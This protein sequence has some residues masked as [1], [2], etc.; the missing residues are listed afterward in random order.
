MNSL[1][2]GFG[3]GDGGGLSDEVAEAGAV[4]VAR[5]RR[6]G[7]RE[8]SGAKTPP[9]EPSTGPLPVV[10]SDSGSFRWLPTEE[11]QSETTWLLEQ[12]DM[13]WLVQNRG[14]GRDRGRHYCEAR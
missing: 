13:P 2:L 6:A 11:S 3:G 7:A 5:K 1:G 14:Q 9:L 4:G 10:A 12:N 8:A